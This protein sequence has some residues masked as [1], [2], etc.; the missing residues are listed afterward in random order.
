MDLQIILVP[1]CRASN[2]KAA[3]VGIV[4]SLDKEAAMR[5]LIARD[6]NSNK[7]G[8]KVVAHVS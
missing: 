8:K 3:L 5:G 1:A 2:T 6:K 4:W 7:Y